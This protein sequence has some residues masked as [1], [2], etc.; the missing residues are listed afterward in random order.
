LKSLRTMP[1]L[2]VLCRACWYARLRWV[3]PLRRLASEFASNPRPPVPRV[4]LLE[5]RP[6][7]ESHVQ[8][9]STDPAF[10]MVIDD[11][12][13]FT[14][15]SRADV[16]TRVRR[17]PQFHHESE[18]RW[19][20]PRDHGELAW[21]YRAAQSYLFSNAAHE[22]WR[23]L[24]ILSA[25]LGRVLDYGAGIGNNAL[26]LAKRGL[27]VDYL[28]ISEIQSQ[29]A[30][31]RA[32]RHGLSNMRFISPF[33]DGTFDPVGCIADTYGAI[34]LQD[35]LEHVPNYDK[36]LSHL[37]GHLK[38]GGLIVETSPFC[39]TAPA[40]ALHLPAAVPLEVAMVGMERIREGVWRKAA[41][42][43][44]SQHHAGATRVGT[45]QRG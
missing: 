19:C 14:G 18:F 25:D 1:L 34:V 33:V 5:N 13:A 44:A 29:F 21:F 28:E 4:V 40:V 17:F 15:M 22:Y 12:V 3:R 24:D 20:G 11:L 43:S 41:P 26:P 45:G 36:L 8:R 6:L 23:L 7:T 31:F 10:N 9:I 2:P 16:L 27:D 42:S 30:R 38:P 39:E 32:S 37:I 35:V